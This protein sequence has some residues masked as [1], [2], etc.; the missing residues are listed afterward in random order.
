MAVRLKSWA[1]NIVNSP[2]LWAL[3]IDAIDFLGFILNVTQPTGFMLDFLQ[4]IAI[5]SVFE[6]PEKLLLQLWEF[7]PDMF[8]GVENVA[9]QLVPTVTIAYLLSNV[10]N[11]E[12]KVIRHASRMITG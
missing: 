11:E 10:S 12:K 6:E 9:V 2:I 4:L 3:G 5:Y 8:G 1:K 7:I